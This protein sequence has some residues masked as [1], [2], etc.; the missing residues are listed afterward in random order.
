[1]LYQIRARIAC[2]KG[3]GLVIERL[4]VR[5]PAGAVG[6]F[7]SPELTFCADFFELTFCANFFELTFYADSLDLTFC[8][9]LFELAFCC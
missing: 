6:E 3:A 4:Q 5:V 9:D 7:S 1:M 8:A 2:S